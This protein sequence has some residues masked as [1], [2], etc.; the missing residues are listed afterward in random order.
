MADVAFATGRCLVRGWEPADA[1]RVFDIYRR[2]EVSRWLGSEPQ[3]MSGL[4]EAQAR[5]ARWSKLNARGDLAGCWAVERKADGV[6]AGAVLLVPLPGG[7]GEF[8]VG[9]HFHPDSWGQGLA[10]EAARGVLRRGFEA[11]LDEVLA[12]VRPANS[13]S[14]A[15]C[16][17]LGMQ[18]LGRTGRYYDAE[19]ELFRAISG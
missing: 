13:A 16:R 7:D 4:A 2:W 18:E 19:L 14:I 17:R 5:V 12:V 15:V 8:E 6:V 1:E 9:W 3:A 10:S 11:G